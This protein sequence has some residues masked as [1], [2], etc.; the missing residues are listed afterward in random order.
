MDWVVD[1]N[2]FQDQWRDMRGGNIGILLVGL[3]VCPSGSGN[4]FDG[5]VGLE[6]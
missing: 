1:K 6:D 5:E 3:I 4:R 2:S